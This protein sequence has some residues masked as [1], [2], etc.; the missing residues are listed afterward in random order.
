MTS[1]QLSE[2]STSTVAN[3]TEVPLWKQEGA[4]PFLKIENV[5]KKFGEFT[6][7]DNISLY[8]YKN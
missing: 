5:T 2:L 6:A 7:V 8:I 4:E 1:S 3:A